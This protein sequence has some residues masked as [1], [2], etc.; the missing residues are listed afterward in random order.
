VVSGTSFAT[1]VVLARCVSREE[2]GGYYLALSV[3]YFV[4]GIQEQLVSAPYMIYCGRKSSEELR[5]YAGSALLHQCV[6]M[7]ATALLL[8]AAMMCGLAPSG[9]SSALALLVFAAPLLLVRE[10][11]RQMSFAHLDLAR[12]A[13]IDV[14]ASAFQ[15][16]ALL[17]LV[18]FGQMT[19]PATLATIAVSSGLAT[20]GWLATSRQAMIG[21]ARAAVRDWISNWPFA[22]WALASQLLASTTPYVMPWIVALTH[23]EAETGLLGAA[24]TL[25]GLSSTLLQ[26]LANFLSPQAAQAFS[27]GGL[28]ELQSVLLKTAALFAAALGSVAV[29]AMLFGEQIAL[30]VFGP[31]FAGAGPIIGVL[32]L[33]VLANSAGVA[34]GNGLWAMERPS[35]NFVADLVSLLVVIGATIVLVPRFGPLGAAISTLAGTSTDAVV[36]LWILRLAMREMSAKGGA[37]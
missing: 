7:L 35:A 25:V 11:A 14:V 6:L 27:R 23:G 5:E 4:R 17:A 36:R 15:L 30:L 31:Q 34:A 22:R 37:A 12:A 19:V 3:F 24:T 18:S 29:I 33:S 20:V 32:S 1:S 9:A 8:V 26:G 13:L 16:V 2:L 21:R 28:A 10:F